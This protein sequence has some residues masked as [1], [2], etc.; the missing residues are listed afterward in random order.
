MDRWFTDRR[1]IVTLVTSSSVV[2]SSVVSI[3]CP[4][5]DLRSPPR[6]VAVASY[7]AGDSRLRPARPPE[8]HRPDSF[9]TLDRPARS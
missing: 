4:P 6:A 3:G 8:K 1:Q 9:F 5:R 2:V 7:D